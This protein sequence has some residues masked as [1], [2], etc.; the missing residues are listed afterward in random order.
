MSS[1]P[2]Q[3][4][5]WKRLRGQSMRHWLPFTSIRKTFLMTWWGCTSSHQGTSNGW[6]SPDSTLKKTQISVWSQSQMW[7]LHT[8][9]SSLAVLS[10]LS[11]HHLQTGM[12]NFSYC[13]TLNP[14]PYIPNLGS[15]NSVANKDMMSKIW[16]NGDAIIENTVRKG[17]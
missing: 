1:S 16:T 4:L 6:N 10:V 15:S 5:T 8:R 13:L 14:L 12:D 2:W 17:G 7:I 9:M 11:S 3:P